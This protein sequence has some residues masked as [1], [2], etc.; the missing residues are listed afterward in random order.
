[1]AGLKKI[2]LSLYNTETKKK[3]TIAGSNPEK[4]CL[5]TCGPTVYDYAHIGNFR[6]YVV[7][8]LVR[9]TLRY[10]N[11]PVFQVMN[12]TDIDDKTIQ[13]ALE[14]NISLQQYT[15][16]LSLIHI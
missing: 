14:K 13:K 4:F 10:L 5:Y 9:R 16:P 12:I 2:C 11:F 7:E 8:D 1:M 3:E 6:T 15:Y